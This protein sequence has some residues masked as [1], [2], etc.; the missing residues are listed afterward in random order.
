MGKYP[1][2]R[3]RNPEPRLPP[4]A[5]APLFFHSHHTEWFPTLDA[6][7]RTTFPRQAA[8]LW[9]IKEHLWQEFLTLAP[10]DPTF[11]LIDSMPLPACLFARAYR[12]KRFHG[13][14]AFGK[15][16]LLGQT[17]YDFKM[18]V[19]VCSPG[20]ISGFPV[21]PANAHEF[22]IVS[23]LVESTLGLAIG[24]RNYWSSETKEEVA[25]GMGVELLAP[26]RS[27]KRDPT[28]EKSVSLS[29]LR[30]RIDAGFSQLTERCSIKR[31]CKESVG[32]GPLAPG[33]S[34]ALEGVELYRC[35]L[36]QPPARHP[37]STAL[38]VAHLKNSH[39]GLFIWSIY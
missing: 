12:R 23:E 5:P 34:T 33:E 7:H 36:A 26:Y 27:K 38:E 20:I 9:K 25:R 17:F 32:R 4:Q 21:A 22:S 1:R 16:A 30:Y 24:N 35:F 28:P 31:V 2:L 29:S 14:A 19:R 6:I 18:H 10:H 37:S 39:I 3:S 8:N 15:D 11:V 13:E